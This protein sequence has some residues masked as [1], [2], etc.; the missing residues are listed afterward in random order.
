VEQV[1]GIDVVVE[2][3]YHFGCLF[4]WGSSEEV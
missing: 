2:D 1:L 4:G 3:A